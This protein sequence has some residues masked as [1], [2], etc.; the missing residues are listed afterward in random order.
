VVTALLPWAIA[1]DAR[2][3][4]AR[5]VL[6][7]GALGLALLAKISALALVLATAAAGALLLLGPGTPR[8]RLRRLIAPTIAVA[9]SIAVFV[10]MQLRAHRATGHWN[11]SGFDGTPW[12]RARLS[13]LNHI[14]YFDRRPWDYLTGFGQ[15]AA[16][17]EP[18]VLKGH[19]PDSHFFPVLIASTFADYYMYDFAPRPK[20]EEPII[21]VTTHGPL[22]VRTARWMRASVAG[23]TVI[24][25]M[26]ALAFIA[27]LVVVLLRRDWERVALL[28]VPLVA[29]VGQ[30]HFAVFYPYD[31]QGPVKGLYLQFAAAPLYGIAG[32][33]VGWLLRRRWWRIA[34]IIPVVALLPIVGYVLY[35][36]RLLGN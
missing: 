2:R 25:L 20:P 6:L 9:V 32:L 15:G 22:A 34:V 23:G 19:R 1:S 21:G 31:D 13:T 27:A 12:G 30:L 28:L 36:L 35:A 7:G 33:A 10:P 3:P 16:L 14:R 26:T 11:A 29:L 8:A 24:A 4:V 5:G 17:R 18:W